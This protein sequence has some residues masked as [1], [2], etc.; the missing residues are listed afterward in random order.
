MFEHEAAGVVDAKVINGAF[1]PWR[2]LCRM[3]RSPRVSGTCR[4]QLGNDLQRLDNLF[5]KS[6]AVWNVQYLLNSG[7]LCKLAPWRRLCRMPRSQRVSGTCSPPVLG[8]RVW[9]LGFEER[10][11]RRLR[12]I[13]P[14]LQF[15]ASRDHT[16][17]GP[18]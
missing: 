2:R 3:P 18:L 1:A 12:E 5:L 4:E 10:S 11:E 16:L 8:L 13:Y 9:G 15:Y 6:K 7:P 17:V 14:P